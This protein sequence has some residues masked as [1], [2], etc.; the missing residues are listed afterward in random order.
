M[1]IFQT[2]LLGT[3]ACLICLLPAA[4]KAVNGDRCVTA[5]ADVGY[6]PSLFE[7]NG[8]A[9]VLL[10]NSLRSAF[11]VVVRRNNAE[12]NDR[13]PDNVGCGLASCSPYKTQ[14]T[15]DY[16]EFQVRCLGG[17]G[18]SEKFATVVRISVKFGALVTNPADESQFQQY[19]IPDVTQSFN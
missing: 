14:E 16:P 10:R 6:R 18:F 9:A 13:D 17:S 7:C 19:C 2:Y 3:V 1:K 15:Q 5:P 11:S 4:A 8:N 12:F